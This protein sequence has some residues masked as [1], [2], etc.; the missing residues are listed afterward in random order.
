MS[1]SFIMLTIGIFSFFSV[2]YYKH[3]AHAQPVELTVNAQK[4]EPMPIAIP[5]FQGNN[6][7]L[8]NKIRDVIVSNLSNSGLFRVLP[9]DSYL[10]QPIINQAPN[11]ENWKPLGA[12]SLIIGDVQMIGNQLHLSFRIWDVFNQVQIIG[13]Q[14]KGNTS[15]IRR[16]GHK[17]SDIIYSQLTGEG[18]YF[19]LSDCLY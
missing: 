6:P 8:S 19:R 1:K 2:D 17:A 5:Y 11:F 4:F 18:P 7:K 15:I 12:A 10:S 16:L 9:P 14:F 13:Q 3:S